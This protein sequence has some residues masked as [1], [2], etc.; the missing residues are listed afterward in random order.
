MPRNDASLIFM[1]AH[2]SLTNGV[3]KHKLSPHLIAD[4]TSLCNV[5]ADATM[6]NRLG[7]SEEKSYAAE[8][9][10][11][12]K[13]VKNAEKSVKK[14][15]A[16]TMKAKRKAD[17][18]A[19]KVKKSGGKADA[20]LKA[21]AAKAMTQFLKAQDA[22]REAKLK[23]GQ[24]KASAKKAVTNAEAAAVIK[25]SIVEYWCAVVNTL[26]ASDSHFTDGRTRLTDVESCQ[27]Y[28]APCLKCKG[29]ACQCK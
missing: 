9:T 20:K 27:V 2:D 10:A 23:V 5:V 28:V 13:A 24:A 21:A 6:R 17:T 11:C 29:S 25:A 15:T 18:T 8:A 19:A 16:K 1:C 3:A 7:E 12:Q 26:T 14:V 22:V 4:C